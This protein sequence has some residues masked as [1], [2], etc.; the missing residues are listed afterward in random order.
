MTSQAGQFYLGTSCDVF[1]TSQVCQ[2]HLGNS[3]CIAV[4]SQIGWFYLGASDM[5]WQR[6]KKVWLIDVSEATSWWSLNVVRDD[7]T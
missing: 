7:P 3:W 4:T 1:A 2:S 5:S 6:A